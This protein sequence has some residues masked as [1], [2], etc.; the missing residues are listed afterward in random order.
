MFCPDFKT[1]CDYAKEGYNLIPVTMSVFAD[2]DTPISAFRKLETEKF[3]FLLES[4]EGNEVTNRYS[5][6]GRNPFLTLKARGDKTIVTDYNGAAVEISGNP[7]AI[8]R[9]YSEKFKSPSIDGIPGFSAGAVGCFAYDTVRFTE[10]LPNIPQDDLNQ[11]D[12]HFMFTDE[13]IAFDNKAK[14]LVLIVNIHAGKSDTEEDLRK[15]YDGA[16][17]QLMKIKNELDAPYIPK[18]K[19]INAHRSVSEPKANISREVFCRNVEKAKEYIKN[20]DIFQVVLSQRFEVENY[21][22][23]FNAYRAIRVINPS[24]YMYY[25]KFD[26]CQIAGASPE[27]L[28]RVENGN[29]YN[30][31]I[32]GSRPRGKTEEE[33]RH[34][35]FELIADAKENAEHM[36]LVDLGRNDVG[37]VSEF[38]SVKVT[39]LK[40]IQRFSHIMHMTSD[41]TG[42]L[43]AD[44]S[45]FDALEAVLPAGTLSGA[46]KVRAMEIIDELENVKRGFYGGAIGYIS[47]GGSLDS[48]I[49]I[50]TALFKDNKAYVQA[51]AGIVYD[52]VPETEY[53][54]TV[55]KAMAMIKAIEKAGDL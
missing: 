15:K 37:K 14:K 46:P 34:N 26:N 3:C 22:D 48:C 10:N 33:D 25:L 52:S 35:E 49:T 47:F 8:L 13:I 53:T 42:K 2:M 11:P 21:S 54:E 40:Y 9:E 45:S 51:G 32:A 30:S 5:F 43:R 39:R 20:G 27:M 4:V 18:P 36:M 28:V 41:V 44:K 12:M 7:T 23:P 19:R 38:G 55:N 50:R 24:P 6:I 17:E 16:I 1:V 31:P 29:V